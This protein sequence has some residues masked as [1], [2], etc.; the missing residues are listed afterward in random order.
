MMNLR[1]ARCLTSKEALRHPAG[2]PPAMTASDDEVAMRVDHP[3]KILILNDPFSPAS[4]RSRA[5][6][7]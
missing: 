2:S 3:D 4:R 6:L 1:S 7:R 5:D